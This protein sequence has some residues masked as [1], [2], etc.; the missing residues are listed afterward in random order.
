MTTP[1]DVLRDRLIAALRS[2]E[3]V[4]ARLRIPYD[5]MADAV[6]ALGEV[7]CR[8]EV[9]GGDPEDPWHYRTASREDADRTAVE[10]RA[11]VSALCSLK[12]TPIGADPEETS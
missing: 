3:T 12:F 10:K 4:T 6:L 11:T 8:W 9:R 7:E 1:E 5:A 2:V